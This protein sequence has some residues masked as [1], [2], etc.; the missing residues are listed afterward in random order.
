M[1]KD[2]N[3]IKK[4]LKDCSEIELPYPFENEVHIKYITLKDEEEYF[5]L[6][7]KFI[8]LLD[9]KIV[10]SNSGQSWTVPINIKNKQGD[11][12]YKSRFFVDKNFNKEKGSV[13]VL[14][15]K[16]II[17]AQQ[18]IIDKMSKSLKLK[19]DENEKMKIILQR[20]KDSR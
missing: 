1:I 15:L 18:E 17:K 19:S 13:E 2:I 9:G 14:E 3:V 5:S 20:I 11:I 7:G 10:L 6:G 12:I 4:H 8:K 16:S